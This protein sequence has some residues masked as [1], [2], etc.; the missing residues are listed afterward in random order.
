MLAPS[1]LLCVGEGEYA[2]SWRFWHLWCLMY[3]VQSPAWTFSCLLEAG[4][5]TCVHCSNTCLW[6]MRAPGVWCCPHGGRAMSP[7][8]LP[9]VSPEPPLAS[10]CSLPGRFLKKT[11]FKNITTK[12]L[13]FLITRLCFPLK[14]SQALSSEI[15]VPSGAWKASG[16]TLDRLVKPGGWSND[17][18]WEPS[19]TR[20]QRPIFFSF[21]CVLF[22][23]TCFSTD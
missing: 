7:G 6:V 18:L 2:H 5:V 4:W 9:G 19:Q 20:T 12:Y 14:G 10:S 16:I 22:P 21:H 1:W 17:A 8:H 3:Q 13:R 11:F 15:S 23:L